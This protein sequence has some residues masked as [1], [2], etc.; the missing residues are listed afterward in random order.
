MAEQSL[1]RHDAP[2]G[3]FFSSFAVVKLN[4]K[5]YLLTA[6]KRIQKQRDFQGPG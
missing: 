6:N 2:F 5:G 4:Y 1:E 3:L